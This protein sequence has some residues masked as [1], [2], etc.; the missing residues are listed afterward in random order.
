MR[1]IYPKKLFICTVFQNYD[2]GD[3]EIGRKI[4]IKEFKFCL[5]IF[6][7]Q[8]RYPSCGANIERYNLNNFSTTM[9]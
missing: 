7:I 3:I 6:Y 5:I 8:T 1:N 9:I 2:Y 4:E